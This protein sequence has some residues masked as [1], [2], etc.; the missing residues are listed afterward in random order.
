MCFC[1]LRPF[2]GFKFLWLAPFLCL[3]GWLIGCLP[4]IND[5]KVFNDFKV[6]GQEPIR[7]WEKACFVGYASFKVSSFCG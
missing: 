6:E 3:W 7:Q 4:K 2:L 1:G 5:L